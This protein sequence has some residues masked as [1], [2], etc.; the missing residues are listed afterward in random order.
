MLENLAN[1]ID[2]S[3]STR[4]RLTRAPNNKARLSLLKTKLADLGKGADPKTLAAARIKHA[5]LA[6]F[7]QKTKE[8][9]EEVRQQLVE[10]QATIASG[11]ATDVQHAAHVATLQQTHQGMID[12]LQGL[13]ASANTAAAAAAAAAASTEAGL[14]GELAEAVYERNTA[15]TDIEGLEE[16]QRQSNE[17][18]TTQIAELNAQH[19]AALAAATAAASATHAQTSAEAAAEAEAALAALRAEH[20]TALEAARE[21]ERGIAAEEAGWA[22]EGHT[23][24]LSEVNAN[25]QRAQGDLTAAL[26]RARVAEEAAAA[27]RAETSAAAARAAANSGGKNATFAAQLKAA[28][29][30]HTA[31]LDALRGW[32]AQR[33]GE[34]ARL[35]AELDTLRAS[36]AEAAGGAAAELAEGRTRLQTLEQEAG[37][38]EQLRRDLGDARAVNQ[39]AADQHAATLQRLASAHEAALAASTAQNEDTIRRLVSEQEAA[40]AASTAAAAAGTDQRVAD[41]EARLV[42]AQRLFAEANA[43]RAAAVSQKDAIVHSIRDELTRRINDEKKEVKREQAAFTK[44]KDTVYGHEILAKWEADATTWRL[45]VNELLYVLVTLGDMQHTDLC[46]QIVKRINEEKIS[47]IEDLRFRVSDFSAMPDKGVYLLERWRANL[48][49]WHEKH[50]ASF[51]VVF[52]P[53]ELFYIFDIVVMENKRILINRQ[54]ET[55]KLLTRAGGAGATPSY[56]AGGAGAAAVSPGGLGG[57]AALSRA[58][59]GLSTRLDAPQP[60]RSPSAPGFTLRRRNTKRNTRK[61]RR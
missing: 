37:Q 50:A 5:V 9:H 42:D 54:F 60:G 56:R 36:A 21:E 43:A 17:A 57:A 33:E 27:A 8:S 49:N 52:T 7:L 61:T 4:D 26:E 22:T 31:E 38:A 30:A 18:H 47:V 16:A 39:A 14:R 55:S 34:V 2:S 20:A 13:L 48:P 29:D 35:Q 24:A 32:L 59:A 19:A 15:I 53:K 12:G 58:S 40:L 25:L 28:T 3:G 1:E 41:V 6:R 44:I 46:L 51:A 10:A 45:E 23:V 11:P